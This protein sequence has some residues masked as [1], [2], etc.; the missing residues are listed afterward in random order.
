MVEHAK[1]CL[2]KHDGRGDCYTSA[3]GDTASRPNK[4]VA[5]I[6]KAAGRGQNQRRVIH[7]AKVDG[8]NYLP[9]CGARAE[10]GFTPLLRGQKNKPCPRC[11]KGVIVM[12]DLAGGNCVHS[13]VS[14][15]LCERCIARRLLR[16]IGYFDG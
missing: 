3:R 1:G 11:V 10:Y 4:R 15:D 16:D 8:F 2:G 5:V 7:I 12:A 9:I 13:M 14:P 6:A